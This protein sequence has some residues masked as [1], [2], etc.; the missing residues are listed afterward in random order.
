MISLQPTPSFKENPRQDTFFEAAA[1]LNHEYGIPD[2]TIRELKE[3]VGL[4]MSLQ[5]E[6]ATKD[7]VVKAR[8]TIFRR[9]R[10]SR[11]SSQEDCVPSTTDAARLMAEQ[12]A[13]T[14]DSAI[15]DDEQVPPAVSSVCE[16]KQRRHTLLGGLTWLKR[17]LS[18]E[19]LVVL[20]G[21]A[22]PEDGEVLSSEQRERDM[23][24]VSPE[25]VGKLCEI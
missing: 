9:P 15:E 19:K 16:T 11:R 10:F 1:C 25:T 21:I 12:G 14:P 7:V 24:N 18:R 6:W 3:D 5:R 17:K 4:I 20:D 8:P 2:V 23:T 22:G 13:S